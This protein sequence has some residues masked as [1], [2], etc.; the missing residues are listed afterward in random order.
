MDYLTFEEGR[1]GGGGYGRIG[2]DYAIFFFSL[3][4]GAD[5]FFRAQKLCMNFFLCI[6]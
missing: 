4:S 5:N 1:G 6:S 3:T 2:L